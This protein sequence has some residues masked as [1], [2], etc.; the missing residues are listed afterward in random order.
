MRWAVLASAAALLAGLAPAQALDKVTFGTNWLAD[1]EAGGYYQALVDGTFT[2]YGLDVKILPGGPMSNG[3]LLLISGK[4]EFYMGGDVLGDFYNVEHDLPVIT[5]AAHMQKNPLIMM[6]HPNAGF[7]KWEDLPK[8]TA[9]VSKGAVA[10]FY[11]WMRTAWG[12]KDEN[13]KPYNYNSATFISDPHSIQ[14]GYVTSEPFSVEQ[15]GHFKPNVFLLSDYGYS[16]YATTI[17]ARRDLVEK[18]P[19]LVQRFV[20]ASTIGWYHYLYGDNKKANDAIKH[21]NAEMTD[22]QIAYSIAKL[23]EYGI[24]DSGDSLTK[25]IGAMSDAH[26]KDFFDKMVKAGLVK[27]DLDYKKGYTLQFVNKGVGLDLRP[28]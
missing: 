12:F 19:D 26:M 23:K 7:D 1:P 17:I 9:I 16:S 25:G 21:D 6:S 18:Q 11:S 10:T 5:V 24:V 15:Q 2:K 8:A 28:K 4:I 13:V 27:A 3:G 20:D 22:D 14:Q